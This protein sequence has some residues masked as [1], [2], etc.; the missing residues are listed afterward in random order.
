MTTKYDEAIQLYNNKKYSKVYQVLLEAAN[1]DDDVKAQSLLGHFY[2]NG[3]VIE[4]NIKKALKRYAKATKQD[5]P[6]ACYYIALGYKEGTYLNTSFERCVKYLQKC[7][8]LPKAQYQLALC[9]LKGT[10]V[11]KD[12]NLAYV[13]LSSASDNND[14]NA[15]LTL[16]SLYLKNNSNEKAFRSFYRAAQLDNVV[17]QV[18]VAYCYAEGIGIAKNVM[19]ALEWYK[20]AA[21]QGNQN[22]QYALKILEISWKNEDHRKQWW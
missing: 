20:K 7:Q 8:M 3:I 21:E 17:G 5:D 4:K 1:E 9:Y 16:G 6:E 13:L 14:V 10:G 22:A 15:A 11:D 2:Y 19:H 12:E 18:N